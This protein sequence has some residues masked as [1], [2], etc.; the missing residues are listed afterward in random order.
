VSIY[1][2]LRCIDVP[3]LLEIEGLASHTD[4]SITNINKR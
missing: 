3:I 1:E 4:I 2:G